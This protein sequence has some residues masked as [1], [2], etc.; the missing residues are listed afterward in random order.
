MLVSPGLLGVNPAEP[1]WIQRPRL[2]EAT[3]SA[4]IT[5]KK[6]KIEQV[7]L[8]FWEQGCCKIFLLCAF[9]HGMEVG[10]QIFGTFM[11][12]IFLLLFN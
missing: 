1:G 12:L 2:A 3:V 5:T 6:D 7:K 9:H 11:M 10:A 4:G 8:L